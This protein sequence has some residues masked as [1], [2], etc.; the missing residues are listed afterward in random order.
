MKSSL[1]KRENCGKNMMW[2]SAPLVDQAIIKR[3]LIKL[4][5]LLS[6]IDR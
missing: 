2:S 1:Q 6:N 5:N 4:Q 3:S